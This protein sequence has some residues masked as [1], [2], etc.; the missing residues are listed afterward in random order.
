MKGP[1]PRKQCHMALEYG[2]TSGDVN[3]VPSSDLFL[4]AGGWDCPA[5]CQNKWCTDSGGIIYPPKPLCFCGVENYGLVLNPVLIKHRI[6]LYQM[7]MGSLW[8]YESICSHGVSWEDHSKGPS[9]WNL[10]RLWEQILPCWIGCR[11]LWGNAGCPPVCEPVINVNHHVVSNT[12]V[13][14]SCYIGCLDKCSLL[15]IKVSWLRG[16]EVD[17]I[18]LLGCWQFSSHRQLFQSVGW[19][20]R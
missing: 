17:S 4:D 3:N 16:V 11:V 5:G 8:K 18:V 19:K 13:K 20:T 10:Y 14:F 7:S 15:H 9:R 12:R 6:D 1:N 2:M